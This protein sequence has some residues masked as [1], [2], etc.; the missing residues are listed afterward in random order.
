MKREDP[1]H[2]IIVGVVRALVWKLGSSTSSKAGRQGLEPHV[3]VAH[4]SKPSKPILPYKFQVFGAHDSSFPSIWKHST[5][6]KLLTS[7]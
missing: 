2:T 5:L 7:V 1:L 3:A 4:A 6:R